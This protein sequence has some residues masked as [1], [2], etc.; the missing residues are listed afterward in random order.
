[1]CCL[2]LKIWIDSTEFC[3]ENHHRLRLAGGE[4]IA[5]E[6]SHLHFNGVG[7]LLNEDFENNSLYQ[8]L[9]EKY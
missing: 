4:P 1:L 5:L 8:I 7:D 2:L 9:S 3:A 6:T